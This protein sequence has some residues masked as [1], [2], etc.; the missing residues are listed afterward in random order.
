MDNDRKMYEGNWKCA[1]CGAPITKLPFEPKS[2]ENLKCIDCFKNGGGNVKM[3]KA[4]GDGKPTFEGNWKC[5]K[6]S[7]PINKLPFKPNPERL[8]QLKCIDCFKAER[9]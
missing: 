8:D 9:A 2:T 3:K 1:G 7:K 4:F 6:C 5:G